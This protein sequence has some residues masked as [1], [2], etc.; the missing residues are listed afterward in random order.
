MAGGKFTISNPLGMS[1]SQRKSIVAS[2]VAL[3]PVVE[4]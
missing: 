3:N 2:V 4:Y 1:I